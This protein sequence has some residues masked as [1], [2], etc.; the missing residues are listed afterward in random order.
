MFPFR[1][2]TIFQGHPELSFYRLNSDRPLRLSK[3]IVPG[4][5]ERREILEARVQGV[6]K[7]FDHPLEGVPQKHIFDA[8]ALLWTA[9]RVFGR[10]ANRIPIE[11]E[12]DSEGL[13]MEYVM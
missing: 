3:K 13:R 7:V 12:W 2:R 5:D 4:R 10:A 6:S 9:R 11:P 1:Q 8:I